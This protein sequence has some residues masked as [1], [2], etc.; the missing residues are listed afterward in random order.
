MDFCLACL[1]SQVSAPASNV[2]ARASP[3]LSNLVEM[4]QAYIINPGPDPGFAKRLGK[5]SNLKENWLIWPQN[6]L[7]LHDLVVKRGGGGRAGPN[8]PIP[9][10]APVKLRA[11]TD[12]SQC[13]AGKSKF[14]LNLSCMFCILLHGACL[15]EGA[16]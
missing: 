1:F 2:D 6:R 10:S 5:V 7:N 8:R 13:F 3:I 12:P 4:A 16:K 9:G 11:N 14:L 15:L